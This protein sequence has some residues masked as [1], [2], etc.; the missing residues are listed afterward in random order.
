MLDYMSQD[1]R[2]KTCTIPGESTSMLRASSGDNAV[3]M[4]ENFKVKEIKFS[5]LLQQVFL[6]LFLPESLQ[7]CLKKFPC[8]CN[9]I[10]LQ[11]PN[12]FLFK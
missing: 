7:G 1:R 10:I 6:Q 3:N 9:K 5:T 8:V 11:L 2:Q 4:K 12:R